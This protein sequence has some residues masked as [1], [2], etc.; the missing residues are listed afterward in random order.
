MSSK[1]ILIAVIVLVV[2]LGG[3]IAG[4]IAVDRSKTREE[5]AS[6]A[7]A[8]SMQLF[9]FNVDSIDTVSIDNEDGHFLITS[10]NG[11]WELK[12]TDYPND[13]NLNPYYITAVVTYMCD[14]QAVQKVEADPGKLAS[15]GLDKPVVITCSSGSTS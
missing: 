5:N 13:V 7:E 8:D 12:E 9:N 4:Y 14:L 11:P 1:K 2:L 6:Q 15:Y 3:A 10:E